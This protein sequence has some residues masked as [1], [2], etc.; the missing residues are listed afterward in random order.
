MAFASINDTTIQKP[1]ILC[2]S[3]DFI[4]RDELVTRTWERMRGSKNKLDNG[5]EEINR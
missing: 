2:V 1:N 3:V 5:F 4:V